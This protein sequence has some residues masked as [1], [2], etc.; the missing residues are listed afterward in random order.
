LDQDHPQNLT[1]TFA[2]VVLRGVLLLSLN[3]VTANLKSWKQGEARGQT[4]R[5]RIA[6]LHDGVRC[7]QGNVPSVPSSHKS[8]ESAARRLLGIFGVVKNLFD[9]DFLQLVNGFVRHMARGL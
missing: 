3:A 2:L 6:A 5:F 9:E 7:V 8:S 1:I 4:E